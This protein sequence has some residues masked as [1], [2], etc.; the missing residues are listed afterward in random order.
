MPAAS[1]RARDGER[2]NVFAS[3]RDERSAT[4]CSATASSSAPSLRADELAERTRAAARRVGGLRQRRSQAGEH[5]ARP[6]RGARSSAFVVG[7][8]PDERAAREPQRADVERAHPRG[9]LVGRADRDLR[10]AAA[11]V[12]DGDA[13]RR[14]LDRAEHAAVGEARLLLRG[15]HADASRRGR[16]TSDATSSSAFAA[17]RPGEVTMISSRAQSSRRAEPACCRAA[18]SPPASRSRGIS[19]HRSIDSPSPS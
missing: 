1:V 2:S 13:R 11:D 19:P 4:M 14:V 3:R 7:G 8:S 15:E 12:A 6:R 9:L 16:A 10:R 17:C 18:A 5:A